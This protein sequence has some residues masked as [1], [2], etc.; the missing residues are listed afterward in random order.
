MQRSALVSCPVLLRYS[1]RVALCLELH[2]EGGHKGTGFAHK[3]APHLHPHRPCHTTSSN[4]WPL[5]SPPA[6]ELRLL[7]R[8]C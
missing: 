5:F 7:E 3:G 1:S 6:D 4:S 8:K 2:P